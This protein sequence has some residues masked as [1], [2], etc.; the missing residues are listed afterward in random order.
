MFRNGSSISIAIL[1]IRSRRGL[2]AGV[3]GYTIRLSLFRRLPLHYF[4]CPPSSLISTP[5][6]PPP[7]QPRSLSSF[8]V[9][10]HRLI[11]VYCRLRQR[12]RPRRRAARRSAIVDCSRSFSSLFGPLLVLSPFDG[13]LSTIDATATPSAPLPSIRIWRLFFNAVRRGRQ[14]GR[15]MAWRSM[16]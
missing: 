9:H 16:L 4:D 6:W 2:R 5:C 11:V 12:R 14:R 1:L 13:P 10:L 7:T 8:S 3:G 15:L